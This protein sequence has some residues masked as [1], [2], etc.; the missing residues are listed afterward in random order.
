[1]SK[2][3]YISSKTKM[4]NHAYAIR[5][6]KRQIELRRN[7][8]KVSV[9][10]RLVWAP[11]DMFDES[12][13]EEEYLNYQVTMETV[14]I[15]LTLIEAA[16]PT[17]LEL[18]EMLPVEV[19]SMILDYAEVNNRYF[20]RLLFEGEPMVL[21]INSICRFSCLCCD[22]VGRDY[23]VTL[24]WRP[25]CCDCYYGC[26]SVCDEFIINEYPN[27]A[28]GNL[29]FLLCDDRCKLR[30]DHEVETVLNH[31]N[32]SILIPHVRTGE[33]EV[34]CGAECYMSSI[35]SCFWCDHIFTVSEISDGNFIS[36]WIEDEG[37]RRYCSGTCYDYYLDYWT[38]E[39]IDSEE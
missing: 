35:D 13:E 17:T 33:L 21:L 36:T 16:E 37:M 10:E 30:Q 14:S 39:P 20:K 2:R 18:F 24:H 26:C 3:N 9:N 32:N 7:E 31:V 4:I 28:K 29:G 5:E 22:V 38:E 34:Y 25:I 19:V 8:K 15:E 6:E 23:T 1:M 12:Y 11:D 27:V